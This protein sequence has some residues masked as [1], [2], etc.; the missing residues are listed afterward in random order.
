MNLDSETIYYMACRDVLAD[1]AVSKEEE[2]FLQK[3]RAVLELDDDAALA[4]Q[5]KAG[6]GAGHD[7]AHEHPLDPKG[8]FEACCRVG[9]VDGVM[10]L[11]E[12]TLL[13]ELS[14]VLKLPYDEAT[15]IFEATRPAGATEA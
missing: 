2:A 13:T 5:K 6:E 3:L 12:A 1:F 10:E 11:S 14:E 7:G 9:W 8:L 15:E 4:I